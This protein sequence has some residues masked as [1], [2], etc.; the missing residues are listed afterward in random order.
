M[1]A[2]TYI[3][4]GGARHTVEVDEG[5][6]LMLG[7]TLNMVPGVE[8]MC[9]GICSCATCHCYIPDKWAGRIQPPAPGEEGMLGSASHR[10]ANSRL[11]CQ[12]AVT[13]DM[14]GLEVEL[15]PE[16]GMGY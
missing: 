12:V 3:E 13:A 7:A 8:G 1:V 5:S 4:H 11:G 2:I 6:N 16:Q 14:D 15:P 10:R 9:G